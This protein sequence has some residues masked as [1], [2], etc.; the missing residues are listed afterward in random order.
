MTLKRSKYTGNFVAQCDTCLE[1][2]DFEEDDHFVVATH[3]LRASGWVPYKRNNT[4]HHACPD[5][6]ELKGK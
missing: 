2:M 5:C 4:W 3:I 6:N 1:I